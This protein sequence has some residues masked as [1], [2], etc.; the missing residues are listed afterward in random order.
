V[1]FLRGEGLAFCAGGGLDV[2]ASLEDPRA[3]ARRD[4]A[5]A[6]TIESADAVVVAGA[7]GAARGVVV[8]LTLAC[9]VRVATPAASFTAS[10]VALGLFGA[11]RGTVRLPRVV[12]EGA[13]PES[14]LSGRTVDA[15]QAR[16]PGFVS[17]V[18]P[19]P[20]AVAEEIT[21]RPTRS[22]SSS[23][24]STTGPRR[25]T[26]RRPGPRPSLTSSQHTPTTSPRSEP[27]GPN[28]R[29][30]AAP[31]TGDRP[32]QSPRVPVP[33]SPHSRGLSGAG[34]IARLWALA[35]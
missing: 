30:T 3:F 24:A 1:A 34:G 32:G 20:G 4:Q 26:R 18:T 28:S 16:E 10:G 9:D 8:E 33:E 17:R 19:E 31:G 2:V 11:W 27:V 25:P 35:S 22:R 7:D 14:S 29:R 23:A 21:A 5:A 12:G 15:E 13:A 6:S